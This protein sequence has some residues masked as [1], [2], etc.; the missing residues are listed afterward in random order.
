M[1]AGSSAINGRTVMTANALDRRQWLTRTSALAALGAM[2]SARPAQAH[3]DDNRE[4]ADLVI[5]VACLGYTLR[6]NFPGPPYAPVQS[7]P[8]ADLGGTDSRGASFIVE[9]L[10]YRG[11]TIKEA[12]G[13]DPFSRRAI[14]HWF[15]R[16]WFVSHTERPLPHALTTQEFVLGMI[17]PE[18]LS[19]PD[20]LVS[21]GLEGGPAVFHR[22]VIGGTGRYRHASGD[23]Q[24]RV[25]G[26][27][28]TLLLPGLLAPTF[29]FSFRF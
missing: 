16:G 28:T 3:D 21:S 23:Q 17:T 14:G 26:T 11:G 19:P 7:T 25:I 2:W 27:N 1:F 9:G 4:R 12:T 22:A 24:E 8:P 15:C 6:P 18:Q 5:D 13:F 29:R 10:I 20:T